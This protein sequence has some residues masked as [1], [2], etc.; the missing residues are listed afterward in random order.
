MDSNQESDLAPVFGDLS[1]SE[2]LSEIRPPEQLSEQ[3]CLNL[4]VLQSRSVAFFN[5]KID[6]SSFILK[7]VVINMH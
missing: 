4:K 6:R 7:T 3:N 1:Q 2:K 5:V